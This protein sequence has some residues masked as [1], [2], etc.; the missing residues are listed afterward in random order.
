MDAENDQAGAAPRR[1][2]EHPSNEMAVAV[3]L[4]LPVLRALTSGTPGA[5]G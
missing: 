1:P 4:N 3:A 5:R 2:Y